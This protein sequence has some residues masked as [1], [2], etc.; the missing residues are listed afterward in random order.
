MKS[1]LI[2]EDNCDI[3]ENLEEILEME[4]YQISTAVNGKIGIEKAKLENPGLILCDI[5]MPIKDGY[6]VWNDLGNS[7]LNN[8]PPF[9]F[10]TSSAQEKEIALGKSLGVDAYIT[11]PF[12]TND[13]LEVIKGLV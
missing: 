9:I 8:R 2:I 4:G 6:E 13:L 10:L 1:I 12:Q 11:K 3:R 7:F 5:A